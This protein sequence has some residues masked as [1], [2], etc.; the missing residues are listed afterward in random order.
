MTAIYLLHNK[1][2]RGCSRKSRKQVYCSKL[3]WVI[4]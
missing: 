4:W 2:K 1:T 3:Y